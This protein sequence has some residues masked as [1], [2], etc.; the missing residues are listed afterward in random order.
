MTYIPV[1]CRLG[2]VQTQRPSFYNPGAKV[3]VGFRSFRRNLGSLL[4]DL[5]AN[6]VLEDVLIWHNIMVDT[7]VNQLA[8]QRNHVPLLIV[9]NSDDAEDASSKI[10]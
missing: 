9:Q 1:L 7:L 8:I 2:P 5:E 10:S 6:G 4:D 3:F